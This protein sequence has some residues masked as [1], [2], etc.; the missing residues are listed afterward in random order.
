MSYIS[1][2][3]RLILLLLVVYCPLNLSGQVD[4]GVLLVENKRIGF[5]PK[6]DHSF[7]R[8]SNLQVY[9][10]QTIEA[11]QRPIVGDTFFKKD[12]A[13]FQPY[14]AFN[15]GLD[16]TALLNDSIRIP[17][18]IPFPSSISAPQIVAVFPSNTTI[19][20][21]LLKIYIQFDQPMREGVAYKMIHLYDES[22]AKVEEPFVRIQPELWDIEHER[23]TLWLDPGRIKRGLNPNEEIGSPLI[24]GFSYRLEIDA[25]WKN[26]HGLPLK[27]GWSQGFETTSPDRNQPALEQLALTIPNRASL[28]PLKI[29]FKEAMDLAL[30]NRSIQVFNAEGQRLSGEVVLEGQMSIWTFVPKE[31]WLPGSYQLRIDTNLE[32]LA[33]NNFNRP[34]DRDLLSPHSD[35]EETDF[36]WYPFSIN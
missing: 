5:F 29:D 13:F 14:F 36:L 30:L 22:G 8:I 4:I 27:K 25:S 10:G 32:D 21:N 35:M 23:I 19:P 6:E 11:G 34:F 31:T 28:E 9:V 2:S 18:Q 26:I 24:Q 16:Y 17:F 12:T 15:Y 7:L 20:A 1:S 3:H 33:G